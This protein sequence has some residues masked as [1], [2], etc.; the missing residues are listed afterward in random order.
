MFWCRA[1]LRS[2]TGDHAAVVRHLE[3]T[4]VTGYLALERPGS[5][6]AGKLQLGGAMAS[7]EVTGRDL[8]PRG[9]LR[10]AQGDG[11]RAARVEVAA[12]GW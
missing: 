1:S 9:R 12:A 5:V 8:L 11:V 2:V 3:E 6:H 4:L 10:A 7:D